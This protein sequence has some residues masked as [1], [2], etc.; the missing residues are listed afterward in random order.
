MGGA[1]TMTGARH[2]AVALRSGMQL[3]NC[4]QAQ[5]WLPTTEYLENASAAFPGLSPTSGRVGNFQIIG[6]SRGTK[7]QNPL[8]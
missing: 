1:L 6:F 8:E 7:P 4:H 5:G 2:A 3:P